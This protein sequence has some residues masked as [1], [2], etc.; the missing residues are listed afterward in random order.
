[1]EAVIRLFVVGIVLWVLVWG[2]AVDS[3]GLMMKITLQ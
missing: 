1:M 2:S 3:Y